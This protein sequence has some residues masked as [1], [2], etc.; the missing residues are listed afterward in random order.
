MKKIYK[1]IILFLAILLPVCIFTFLKIFGNNQFNIPLYYQT[2][3]ELINAP[4]EEV[5][6]PYLFDFNAID[7]SNRI[8]SSKLILDDLITIIAYI[9][10]I[11]D[12]YMLHMLSVNE[13]IGNVFQMVVF[14]NTFK[15]NLS[16]YENF[17]FLKLNDNIK[18]FWNCSLLSNEYDNWVLLD[19][20]NRIRGYYEISDK[21]IDRLIVEIKILSENENK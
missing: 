12:N 8:D 2:Q 7:N 5:T 13:R 9:P 20:E 10:V 14:T 17:N 15:N 16:N 21:E 18:A 6:A 3:E 19:S 11:D 1:S 4:C